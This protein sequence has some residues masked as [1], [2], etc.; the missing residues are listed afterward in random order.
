MAFVNLQKQIR[1]GF[2]ILSEIFTKLKLYSCGQCETH[3]TFGIF[4]SVMSLIHYFFL[5]YSHQSEL[6]IS[7]R[8]CH[9]PYANSA[10]TKQQ[11]AQRLFKMLTFLIKL[12]SKWSDIH[13]RRKKKR[14][15]MKR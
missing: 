4:S 1:V 12:S 10:I 8:F 14:F 2:V 13:L 9:K 7:F 3:W 11:A 5:D 15:R 6:R